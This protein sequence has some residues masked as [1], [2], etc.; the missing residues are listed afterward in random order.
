M[1]LKEGLFTIVK[2]LFL[3]Y[4]VHGVLEMKFSKLLWFS[5][6]IVVN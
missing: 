3:M 2:E 1:E 5:V 6:L 4:L